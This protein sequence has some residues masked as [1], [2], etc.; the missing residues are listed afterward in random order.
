MF[1]FFF[2]RSMNWS[3]GLAVLCA[4]LGLALASNLLQDMNRRREG[5][6]GGGGG[7]RRGRGKVNNFSK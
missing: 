2:S 6:G 3:L 7:G 5:G 4:M 1:L